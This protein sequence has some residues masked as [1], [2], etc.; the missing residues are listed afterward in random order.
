MA[1]RKSR[2]IK[3]NGERLHGLHYWDSLGDGRLLVDTHVLMPGPGEPLDERRTASLSRPAPF[4]D[5]PEGTV[6]EVDLEIHGLWGP[7]DYTGRRI[8]AFASSWIR[9]DGPREHWRIDRY[10][11]WPEGESIDSIDRE[12]LDFYRRLARVE[13]AWD[14]KDTEDMDGD[15]RALESDVRAVM[16]P[17]GNYMSIEDIRANA[18][19]PRA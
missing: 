13:T 7:A 1:S 4:A 12:R 19:T 8:V 10:V 14:A 18:L 2:W 16:S 9:R 17:Q 11:V 6:S 15:A 5:A 3:I